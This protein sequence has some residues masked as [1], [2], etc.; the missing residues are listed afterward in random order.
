MTIIKYVDLIDELRR[1]STYLEEYCE[2]L[3]IIGSYSRG[4]Y[5]SS[6]DVDIFIIIHNI[7]FKPRVMEIL[8]D[9]RTYISQFSQILDVKIYTKESFMKAYEGVDHFQL[10]L[11]LSTGVLVIGHPIQLELNVSLVKSSLLLW[12]DRVN[13]SITF[14]DVQAQ[15][16]GSCFV[17]YSALAWFYF[18]ERFLYL[19]DNTTSIKREFLSTFFEDMSSII[20]LNYKMIV[21]RIREKTIISPGERIQVKDRK[22]WS[23]SDYS[24]LVKI[25]ER[26][27]KNGLMIYKSIANKYPE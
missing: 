13:E 7:D 11:N 3:Y 8:S 27:A 6:S 21:Q 19:Q 1:I 10:W 12:I 23:G 5:N 2:T 17:L 20:Y 14:L 16:E 25:A 4:E 22:K 26:L 9:L 24:T 15:F 18:V